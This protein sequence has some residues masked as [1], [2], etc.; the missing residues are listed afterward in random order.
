MK[1][2]KAIGYI[3]EISD[4]SENNSVHYVDYARLRLSRHCKHE[5]R[6]LCW[7][8][9]CIGKR[10]PK[11]CEECG[12]W[13]REKM[14]EKVQMKCAVCNIANHGCK[15][16]NVKA[17]LCCECVNFVTDAENSVAERHGRSILD[18]VRD[19]LVENTKDLTKNTKDHNAERGTDV[20]TTGD[21][22]G[23]TEKSEITD[24][25]VR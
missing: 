2:Q 9:N 20:G 23:N 5:E 16:N 13:Y 19:D 15:P 21:T 25:N 6:L 10:M 8:I 18:L 17:W 1:V 12:D 7:F 11:K 24:V 4:G 14:M 22:K 3:T